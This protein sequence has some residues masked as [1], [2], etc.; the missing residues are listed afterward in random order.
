MKVE[1]W[2]DIKG[3]EGYY[4]ISNLGNVKSIKRKN[5]PNDMVLK[6]RKLQNGYNYILLW[7]DRKS[8]HFLIHRLVAEA[9][10]EG[11]KSLQVDHIDGNKNNNYYLNL[12]YVTGKENINNPNTKYKNS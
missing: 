5:V 12:R 7:K 4:Q 3:Y 1:I 11:D 10:V 8:K 6:S 2:K 9:F